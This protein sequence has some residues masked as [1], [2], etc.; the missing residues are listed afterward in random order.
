MAL[1]DDPL[2]IRRVIR[3]KQEARPISLRSW[4]AALRRA[5][6]VRSVPRGAS[7]PPGLAFQ[8]GDPELRD[9]EGSWWPAFRWLE[10]GEIAVVT[11][12]EL[13]LARTL[14]TL[15][16]QPIVR[17]ARSLAAKLRAEVVEEQGTCDEIGFGVGEWLRPVSRER[18][19]FILRDPIFRFECRPGA[20]PIARDEWR[21]VVERVPTLR[22]LDESLERGVWRCG[23][24]LRNP[25]SHP[26]EG[27]RFQWCRGTVV[28]QRVAIP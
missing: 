6:G 9:A 21:A 15:D 19:C 25:G 26:H 2:S 12:A 5:S 16:E 27:R 28:I 1:E 13:A 8:T 23:A 10:P 4:R 20:P 11:N 24:A 3:R 14:G 17:T 18:L 22:W 7:A